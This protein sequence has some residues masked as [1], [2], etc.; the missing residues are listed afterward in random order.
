MWGLVTMGLFD[1]RKADA[2]GTE[3]R[4]T[5]NA[6]VLTADA[7]PRGAPPF[8]PQ[9]KGKIKAIVPGPGGRSHTLE[10]TFKYSEDHWLAAGMDVPVFLDPEHPD[11]FE[12]DWA[13][14][15]SMKQQAEANNPALADPFAAA[16]RLAKALGITPSEKTA[17]QYERFQKAVTDAAAEPAPAGQLRAVAL[18]ATVRGRYDSGD[19][20]DASTGGGGSHPGVGL[21]SASEAVLS[22]AVPG[23]APY[24]VF[25]PKFKVPRKH[26][27]IPGE[28]MPATVSASDPQKVE[29]LWKEAPGLMDQVTA[30]MADSARATSKVQEGMMA[31]YQAAADQ[32]MANPAAAA[33]TGPT[34]MPPV[35][36]Q[37][38][39]DN[40][41]RS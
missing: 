7:P 23:R 20:G 15:P 8:G 21:T 1:K 30:R 5:V 2:P 4:S 14:V 16:R 28:A 35:A 17:A 34:G 33:A 31:Q 9:S 3:L 13:S 10:S 11:T 18:V 29:I 37:M 38:L 40:L 24:A 41:K 39:I 27:S 12:V 6:L 32:A 36:R 26:L 25:V 19:T 22:V